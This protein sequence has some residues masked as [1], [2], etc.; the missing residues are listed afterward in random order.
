MLKNKTAII[1]G[2]TSGIGY[3]IALTLAKANCNIMLNGFVD[4][5]TLTT[6]KKEISDL[7]VKVSYSSAD[8]TKPA[9]IKEMIAQTEKELGSV[10]ILINN[11]GIQRVFPI[12]SFPDEAWNDVI[13]IDLSSS[14]HTIKNALPV[15]RKNNWGR[16]I[17]IASAHGLVASEHKAA[18]VSAKHGLVGLTKVIALETAKEN[19]TC[20]AICPG[21]VLTPLVEKQINDNASAQK[22]TFEQA[23]YN[24]LAEK[25]PSLQ[26][27]TPEQIGSLVLFLCSDA[28]E[29]IKGAALPIDGGWVSR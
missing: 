8:M 19:I 20:N 18:Y 9:Q 2:S 21:W 16:I 7:G 4:D 17:N 29:Q 5:A 13:A 22:I 14:F 6:I 27:V 10:D 24:L 26:F 25:Q 12:E 1:T 11:A 3:G 15:M 28:A 23:K